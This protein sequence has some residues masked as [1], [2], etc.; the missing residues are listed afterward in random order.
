M[1]VTPG[2]RPGDASPLGRKGGKRKLD[3]YVRMVAHALIRKGFT[4]SH[5][6]ATARNSLE[7]WSAGRGHVRPQVRAGAA[8]HL[9]IQKSIDRGLSVPVVSAQDGPRVTESA[10]MKPWLKKKIGKKAV[11]DEMKR[12]STKSLSTAPTHTV[13][14]VGPHGYSHGWVKEGGVSAKALKPGANVRHERAGDTG[15][16]G[17]I[18]S[19][20]DSFAMIAT[21][22]KSGE[23]TGK[24]MKVPHEKIVGTSG[25]HGALA[26]HDEALA[27]AKAALAGGVNP[28][29]HSGAK[30][31]AAAAA[32]AG[33]NLSAYHQ[34]ILKHLGSFDSASLKK[35][36]SDPKF[37]PIK[38]QIKTKHNGRFGVTKI[39]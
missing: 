27:R 2:G 1:A 22:H 28:G 13:D 39:G 29:G 7:R 31:P 34:H 11:L 12:R 35:M 4:K 30:V 5:A 36:H 16:S 33:S 23:Y 37:T 15:H 9:G 24:V 26:P 25:A 19:N 38:E 14:L 18:I 3:N 32:P 21:K 6:I 8:A 10:D 20:H 17:T